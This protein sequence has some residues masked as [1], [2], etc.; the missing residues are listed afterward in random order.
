MKTHGVN[1]S[2]TI[3]GGYFKTQNSCSGMRT[4]LFAPTYRVESLRPIQTT[5]GK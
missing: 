2:W 5:I 4:M 3:F 1:A